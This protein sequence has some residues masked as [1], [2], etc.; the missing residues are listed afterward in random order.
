MILELATFKPQE[1]ISRSKDV[2]AGRH[3]GAGSMRRHEGN[4]EQQG[5][6]GMAWSMGIKRPIRMG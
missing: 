1:C 2:I 5:A 6:Q 3:W 4:R